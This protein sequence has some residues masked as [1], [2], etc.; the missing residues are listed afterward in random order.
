MAAVDLR[1][2]LVAQL[3]NSMHGL[4]TDERALSRIIAIRSEIDLATLKV[5]YQ[6][7]IGRSLAEMVKSDTTSDYRSLLLTLLGEK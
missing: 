3:Y 2:L 6:Q 7:K 1:L 4:G 5:L